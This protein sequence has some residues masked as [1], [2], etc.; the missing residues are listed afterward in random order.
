MEQIQNLFFAYGYPFV[1][2]FMYCGLIGIP[3]TEESFMVFVGI[4]LSQAPAEGPTL[5]VAGCIAMA[6]LGSVSGMVT[7]YL[8]GYYI[9]KPFMMKYGRLIGL[10]P[11]RWERARTHFQHHAFL[12]VAVGYFIPGIRQINPYLAG[13][14]RARYLTFFLGSLT[15]A[16]IWA[17]LFILLGFFAGSQARRFLAFG[18]IHVILIGIV[19]LISFII[20]TLIHLRK[21]H[22]PVK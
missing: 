5:S 16:L 19:L 18:P 2:V 15:G 13:L 4:T 14:T 3:A 17:A 6:V 21:Q 9:G 11:A 12:A 22:R 10:T 7:A 20:I 8:I 1:F